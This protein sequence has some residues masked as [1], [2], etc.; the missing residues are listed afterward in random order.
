M[1]QMEFWTIIFAIAVNLI[2]IAFMFGKLFQKVSTIESN[3]EHR[4][5]AHE[6]HYSK[7]AEHDRKIDN[8]EQRIFVL[9]KGH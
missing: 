6:H 1:P 4:R 3:C 8:H 7:I 5:T 9:E 2:V